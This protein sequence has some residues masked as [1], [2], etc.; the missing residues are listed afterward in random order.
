M[1]YYIPDRKHD[2]EHISHYLMEDPITSENIVKFMGKISKGY[3]SPISKRQ[4]NF[5]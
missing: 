2:P 5:D 1:A 4:P 3:V